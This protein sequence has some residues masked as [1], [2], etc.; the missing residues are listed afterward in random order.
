MG[1]ISFKNTYAAEGKITSS[2]VSSEQHQGE[3]HK[4]KLNK[5]YLVIFVVLDRKYNA[6]TRLSKPSFI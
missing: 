3:E 1:F 4:K 6:N 2:P 5:T